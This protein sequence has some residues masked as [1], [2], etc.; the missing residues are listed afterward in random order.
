M[1]LLLLSSDHTRQIVGRALS[2]TIDQIDHVNHIES[3]Y[4]HLLGHKPTQYNAVIIE[5]S[6]TLNGTHSILLGVNNYCD[7]VIPIITAVPLTFRLFL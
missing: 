6:V 4:A 7:G 3:F 1:K 2:E 5:D